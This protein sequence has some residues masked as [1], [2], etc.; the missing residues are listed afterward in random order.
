MNV[1]ELEDYYRKASNEEL[2]EV[3]LKAADFRPDAVKAAVAE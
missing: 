2:A 1:Q 3:L